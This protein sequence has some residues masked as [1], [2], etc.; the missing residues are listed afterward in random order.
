MPSATA[1]ALA[2]KPLPGGRRRQTLLASA[3]TKWDGRR[4]GPHLLPKRHLQISSEREAGR[5][6]AH[7]SFEAELRRFATNRGWNPLKK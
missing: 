3:A 2:D 5:K 4:P 6:I 7:V 1:E